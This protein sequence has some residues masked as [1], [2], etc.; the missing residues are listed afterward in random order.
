MFFS[1]GPEP[2]LEFSDSSDSDNSDSEEPIQ[3]IGP[4][5]STVL[6][7][8]A[9]LG[10]FSSGGALQAPPVEAHSIKLTVPA[11]PAAPTK[12]EEGEGGSRGD[13][14]ETTDGRKS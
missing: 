10:S 9:S 8:S 6:H 5:H 12:T 11:A 14:G 13:D 4:G 1:S 2:P 7:K 3:F